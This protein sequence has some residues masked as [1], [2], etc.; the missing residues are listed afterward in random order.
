VVLIADDVENNRNYLRD[1]LMKTNLNVLEAVDGKEA[2]EIVEN[3]VPDLVIA[4]IKMPELN[5]FELL[6]KIKANEKLRHIP[7][8]AYSASV[9]KEQRGLIL[10]S[11]FAGLLVKP[12]SVHDLYEI[13]MRFL[14]Y[15]NSPVLI[16]DEVTP[17]VNEDIKN[18]SE[19]ITS[20]EGSFKE[21]WL[22]FENRQ[23]LGEV[24]KFGKSLIDLGNTHN[25]FIVRTYGKELV[26]AAESFNVEALLSLLKKFNDIVETVKSAPRL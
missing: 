20:L 1:I 22:A 16:P 24:R 17:S 14:P 25:S 19:L 23:P 7:V 12:V 10:K 5:G 2:L 21:G 18:I 13:L 8:V 11:N 4:D 3:L 26:S 6:E 15:R 9:M